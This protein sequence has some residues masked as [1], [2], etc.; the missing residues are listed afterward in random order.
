MRRRLAA[1]TT[2]LVVLAGINP[3]SAQV[4]DW[5]SERPPKPLAARDVK[6]PPYAVKTLPNGLQVIAVSH[7]EQPAVSVRLI[8]RAGSAQDP[9]NRPGLATLAATLLDKMARRLG[10]RVEPL[11]ILGRVYHPSGFWVAEQEQQAL[12]RLA[13]EIAA[14][15]RAITVVLAPPATDARQLAA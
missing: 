3:A 2:V 10:I 7:H 13:L 4:P 11:D 9:D 8:V 5:P 6:F 1:A 14:G 15:Q 12:R